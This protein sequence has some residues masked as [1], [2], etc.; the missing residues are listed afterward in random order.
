MATR[1]CVDSDSEDEIFFGPVTEKEEVIAAPLRNRKT[2]IFVPGTTPL[3][4]RSSVYVVPVV[5]LL[6][7]I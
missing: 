6:S 4:R 3:Y 1:D 2:E 7:E 5:L